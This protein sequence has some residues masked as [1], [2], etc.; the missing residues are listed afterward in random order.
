LPAKIHSSKAARYNDFVGLPS[1]WMQLYLFEVA[2][3]Y[4]EKNIQSVLKIIRQGTDN[5]AFLTCAKRNS[6]E[7]E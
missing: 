4:L 3:L 7:T 5:H 1:I 6:A 2:S